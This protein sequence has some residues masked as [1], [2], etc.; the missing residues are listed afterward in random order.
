MYTYIHLYTRMH[1]YMYR[2]I[3]I[4][5]YTYTLHI[6]RHVCTPIFEYIGTCIHIYCG[7]YI[8]RATSGSIQG[9]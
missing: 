4:Y 6:H 2:H 7:F 5:M 3:D 9:G 8:Q 1:V